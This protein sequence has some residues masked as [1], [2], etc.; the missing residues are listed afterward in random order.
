M[1]TASRGGGGRE[2]GWSG[3]STRLYDTAVSVGFGGDPRVFTLIIYVTFFWVR[4]P[5]LLPKARVA[6]PHST[7]SMSLA[8]YS[9]CGIF[10]LLHAVTSTVL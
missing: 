5:L 9:C 7:V 1:K 3:V 4:L 8:G 10:V 2:G 6:H